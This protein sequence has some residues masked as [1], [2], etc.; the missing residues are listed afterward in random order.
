MQHLQFETAIHNLFLQFKRI[1]IAPLFQRLIWFIWQ[2]YPQNSSAL[3]IDALTD[4]CS[5]LFLITTLFKIALCIQF[6]N[7]EYF[8]WSIFFICMY[9]CCSWVSFHSI[10]YIKCFHRLNQIG[11]I[12]YWRITYQTSPTFRFSINCIITYT[13]Y[14]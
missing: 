6:F 5:L 4:R 11:L 13:Y 10:F 8:I 12:T 1:L 7:G 2:E 3:I 14:S 9:K